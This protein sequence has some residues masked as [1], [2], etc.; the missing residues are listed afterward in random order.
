MP[1]LT[2][3][4]FDSPPEVGQKVNIKGEVLSIDDDGNVE[5]SY[6]EVTSSKKETETVESDD[7]MDSDS[8][9]EKSFRR[10]SKEKTGE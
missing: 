6:D 1:K 5:V 10:Y 3:E 8:E 9:V 2:L 7:S 4:M